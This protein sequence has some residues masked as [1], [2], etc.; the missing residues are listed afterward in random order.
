[1]LYCIT[2]CRVY[3]LKLTRHYTVHTTRITLHSTAMHSLLHTALHTAHCTTL[4]TLHNTR[5]TALHCAL[6][7]LPYTLHTGLCSK[8]FLSPR[9]IQE[10][11]HTPSIKRPA[12]ARTVLLLGSEGSSNND[13]RSSP[14]LRKTNSMNS[15]EFNL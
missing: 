7:T 6:C 13:N 8:C 3:T 14:R 1:M 5:Y 2:Y 9:P 11:V 4:C 15:T 10:V 12:G